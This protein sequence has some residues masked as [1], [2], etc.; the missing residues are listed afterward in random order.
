VVGNSGRAMD[1]RSATPASGRA[2]ATGC[3]GE[4]GSS[5]IGSGEMAALG[6]FLENQRGC[7]V[8]PRQ[9]MHWSGAGQTGVTTL[10][11]H[12]APL[13]LPKTSSSTN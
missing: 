1:M 3:G 2:G 7:C 8:W 5:T 10:A 12:C 11:C 6:T 4:G 13:S 9:A